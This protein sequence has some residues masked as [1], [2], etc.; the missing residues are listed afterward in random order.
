MDLLNI[1]HGVIA[2][3]VNCMSVMGIGWTDYQ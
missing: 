2:H 1:K 3:Q